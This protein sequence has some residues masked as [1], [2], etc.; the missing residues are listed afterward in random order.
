MHDFYFEGKPFESK[1][2]RIRGAAYVSDTLFTFES[3]E[4]AHLHNKNGM[5]DVYLY[6]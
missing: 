2:H 6:R 1:E 5:A 3:L 4:A